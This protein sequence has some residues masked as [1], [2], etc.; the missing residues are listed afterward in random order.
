M[1]GGMHGELDL[2]QLMRKRATVHGSTLR[3]RPLADKAAVVAAVADHLWPLVSAGRIRPVIQT[4]LPLTQA[5]EG[6]RLMDGSEHVGKILLATAA[7]G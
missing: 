4:V 5:A 3:S 7:G 2:G 6:H 1:Q